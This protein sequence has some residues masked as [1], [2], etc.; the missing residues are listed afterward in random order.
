[1][2]R[3]QRK[4]KTQK[5]HQDSKLSKTTKVKIVFKVLKPKKEILP[6]LGVLGVLVAK[7]KV[8]ILSPTLRLSVEKVFKPSH[9]SV[10]NKLPIPADSGAPHPESR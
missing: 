10:L 9:P 8:L 3:A 5:G 1:V 6:F 2:E 7:F 4:D